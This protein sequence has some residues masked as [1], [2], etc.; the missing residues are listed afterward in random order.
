MVI[1]SKNGDVKPLS[2]LGGKNLVSDADGTTVQ[3]LAEAYNKAHTD[4]G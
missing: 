3:L 4:N 1:V 2:E